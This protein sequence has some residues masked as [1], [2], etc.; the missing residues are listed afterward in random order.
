MVT[1]AYSYSVFVPE[2]STRASSTDWSPI[3]PPPSRQ[4]MSSQL[5]WPHEMGGSIS[6]PP[7]TVGMLLLPMSRVSCQSG[8]ESCTGVLPDNVMASMMG[9]VLHCVPR[10]QALVP[11][12]VL[13]FNRCLC[14]EPLQ[15]WIP[16]F[17]RILLQSSILNRF[18]TN[19]CLQQSFHCSA[20]TW[21]RRLIDAHVAKLLQQR[22]PVL[23]GILLQ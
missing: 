8:T 18:Y 5:H 7:S 9:W 16:V 10:V 22:I 23:K 2:S 19:Y 14:C 1:R 3:A 13:P 4:L 17:A 12:M 6:L 20:S 21:F 11:D 15:R